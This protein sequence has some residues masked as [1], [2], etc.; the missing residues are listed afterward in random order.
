MEESSTSYWEEYF[1]AAF[2]KVKARF[3]EI[4]PAEEAGELPPGILGWWCMRQSEATSIIDS[5]HPSKVRSKL[6]V[7]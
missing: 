1:D 2:E 3:S 7:D 5:A 4:Y 6:G